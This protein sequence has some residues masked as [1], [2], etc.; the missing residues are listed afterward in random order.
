MKR[1]KL[2]LSLVMFSLG[3]TSCK[4]YSDIK[5]PSDTGNQNNSGQGK[6]EN[7]PT[8][9]DEPIKVDPSDNPS[10]T[11]VDGDDTDPSGGNTPGGGSGSGDNPGDSGGSSEGGSG[12]GD[13]PGGSGGGNTPGGGGDNPQPSD[14]DNP[15]GDED[16]TD[17]ETFLDSKGEGYTYLDNNSEEKFIS[18]DDLVSGGYIT[19]SQNRP[20]I[21]SIN[22][23]SLGKGTLDIPL[24]YNYNAS[25]STSTN[26]NNIN[27]LVVGGPSPSTAYSDRI[28][29]NNKQLFGVDSVKKITLKEGINV[30]SNNLFENLSNLKE[31]VFPES[32]EEIGTSAFQECS[33]LKVADLN[34]THL[35]TISWRLFDSCT[36]LTRV[37]FPSTIDGTVGAYAFNNC[38]SLTTVNIPNG[39]SN[40]TLSPN[41]GTS[42]AFS[43][44]KKLRS[45]YLNSNL[46]DVPNSAFTDCVS[47]E[48][49]IDAKLEKIDDSAFMN[50]NKLSDIDFS[51]TKHIGIS[52]FKG[53]KIS[54]L[55]L[56]NYDSDMIGA[57]SFYKT[58]VSSIYIKSKK[59]V[60]IFSRAFY[61][62]FNLKSITADPSVGFSVDAYA[63]Y[64]CSLLN[65]VS[66]ISKATYIGN[67]AFENCGTL[68][69]DGIISNM[70]ER[71][72]NSAFTNTKIKEFT[73]T[74]PNSTPGFI[75]QDHFQN[76]IELTKFTYQDSHL[77]FSSMPSVGAFDGCEN[78]EEITL[79]SENKTENL[80]GLALDEGITKIQ[81]GINMFRGCNKLSKIDFSGT[82]ENWLKSTF[83]Q[84][85]STSGTGTTIS[86]RSDIGEAVNLTKSDCKLQVICQNGEASNTSTP[87]TLTKDNINTYLSK[88]FNN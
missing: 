18:W 16:P 78:L 63:F 45:I 17:N 75:G 61:E 88:V 76:C 86:F 33:S 84:Q 4:V 12:S 1:K 31:I 9:P 2:L 52:A 67:N 60:T 6:D 80:P 44:C 37:S 54:S 22:V 27:H 19:L 26:I 81:E 3:I 30:I 77:S 5:S 82:V 83:M 34:K 50:C 14:D 73:Y 85:S 70:S 69:P 62:N 41:D 35:K 39:I 65:E 57:D 72:Y 25:Y 24:D 79:R 11:P 56:P 28:G 13:N 29:P 74:N 36:S 53:T 48:F 58:D 21:E 38:S 87:I 68:T 8:N 20:V 51:N 42:H 40:L 49:T 64:N 15:E 55:S 71:I 23:D 43:G 10:V 46:K 7:N 47:C 32:L 59:S 66:F